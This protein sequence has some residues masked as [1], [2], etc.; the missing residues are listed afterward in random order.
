MSMTKLLTS[1]GLTVLAV[2]ALLL[3][4][5]CATRQSQPVYTESWRSSD[6]KQVVE[7]K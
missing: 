4:T 2:A 3:A 6:G 5:G 1:T 7:Y